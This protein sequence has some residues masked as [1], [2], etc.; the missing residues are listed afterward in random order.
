MPLVEIP[1][2]VFAVW[3][4]TPNKMGGRVLL[5][6]L[7]F[8]PMEFQWVECFPASLSREKKFLSC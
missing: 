8:F 5:K 2:G 4:S 6:K 3:N 7:H 1:A